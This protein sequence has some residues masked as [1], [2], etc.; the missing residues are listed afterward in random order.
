MSEK[1]F[2]SVADL[3]EKQTKFERLADGV[4][5]YTAEGDPNSGVI[6][7]DDSVM[8]IEAQA[9]P[10]L[11]RGLIGHIREVTDKPIRY[12]FL[13]HYHAVRVLGASAYQAD[14]IISSQ[15]TR[16]L[17]VERGQ[18]DY[19]SEL[20]RFPRL[21]QGA[22][23]IPGLTWP[24]LVFETS[25]TLWMGERQVE[26]MH[27]GRGHTKGDAVVW[28]PE[29]KVLFSGDLVE[30]GATPYTGDAY[31][32]DWPTTLQRVRDLGPHMLVPGRGEA[33][34]TPQL[35]EAAIAGT[36]SFLTQLYTAV[37]E[38][39]ADGADLEAAYKRAHAALT[40]QFGDWVIYQHC[41]PFD[42]TRAYDEAGDYP[43]PRIWTAER[44]QEMWHSLQ[45]AVAPAQ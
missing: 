8:V 6:V 28:L 16:E 45:N 41:L 23:S 27:L 26:M 40:P 19:E 2:A 43:D 15:A 9:T 1:Q 31:L 22:D 12:L 20:G 38:A 4:Y 3:E 24:N 36:Q 42:V 30:C 34:R 14:Y 32:K 25:M 29:E 44:D 5:A 7:G 33:L 35:C 21:F 39:R 11:A 10:I 37:V 13:S 18:Q 17:V